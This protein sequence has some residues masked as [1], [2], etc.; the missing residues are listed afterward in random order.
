MKIMYHVALN[1]DDN[2]IK[3]M[4]S[5]GVYPKEG[6]SAVQ[7]ED[8]VYDKVKKYILKWK[9]SEGI[10]YPSFSNEEIQESLLSAR[11]GGYEHGYPMPDMDF[12]YRKA[13]YNLDNYCD[14]C[15]TG[16]KQNNSFYLKSIPKSTKKKIFTTGWVFDE[17]FVDKQ[18]YNDIFKPLDIQSREVL[19]YKDNTPFVDIVQLILHENETNLDLSE[20]SYEKCPKCSK[21]KYQ[22]MSVDFY[23]TYKNFNTPIFKSKEY[24]GSGASAFKR[25]FISK[26]LRDQLFNLKLEKFEWYVPT[27]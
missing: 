11:C 23:P 5:Y 18:L 15:G 14:L 10:R 24:F 6:Y 26:D 2:K 20:Y 1:W 16:L 4:K 22:P 13:T 3:I 12:G 7:I 9:G 8:E 19:K 17:L 21:K 27:K 25:I